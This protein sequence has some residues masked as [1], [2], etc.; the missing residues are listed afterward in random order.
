M[1]VINVRIRIESIGVEW[2]HEN[3][4]FSAAFHPS[5][6]CILHSYSI[7]HF[8]CTIAN[9]WQYVLISCVSSLRSSTT[10]GSALAAYRETRQTP[11]DKQRRSRSST[12]LQKTRGDG[13]CERVLS[14]FFRCGRCILL[15]ERQMNRFLSADRL[16][17][18][19]RRTWGCPTVF[20]P[21]A[22]RR[23]K[24]GHF[25]NSGTSGDDVTAQDSTVTTDCV[26]LQTKEQR[27]DGRVA[28]ADA[29]PIPQ[30]GLSVVATDSL[31]RQWTRVV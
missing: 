1:R 2:P 25:L 13:S 11:H 17:P 29:P 6:F 22:S 12:A 4:I 10:H 15:E 9:R 21:D 16:I 18:G 19:W 27:I 20:C 24:G 14:L 23:Q 7:Y 26:M 3:K 31:V 28:I 30:Q 5:I 8:S